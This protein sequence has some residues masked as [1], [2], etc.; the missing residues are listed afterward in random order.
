MQE[1]LVHLFSLSRFCLGSGLSVLQPI[2][3]YSPYLSWKYG[4]IAQ[5]LGSYHLLPSFNREVFTTLALLALAEV[6]K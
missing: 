6:Q 5:L 3:K 1:G 4:Y 2:G